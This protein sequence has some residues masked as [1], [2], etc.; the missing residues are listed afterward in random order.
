[1]KA[2]FLE[3]VLQQRL[4][5]RDDVLRT[6]QEK[7]PSAN[8]MGNLYMDLEGCPSFRALRLAQVAHHLDECV[9]RQLPWQ[10][11]REVCPQLSTVHVELALHSSTSFKV[12]LPSLFI[13]LVKVLPAVTGEKTSGQQ[14]QAHRYGQVSS[15]CK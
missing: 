3:K 2:L 8:Q 13:F 14:N 15:C 10:P 12:F 6:Q 7:G 9:L 11:H 5:P 4:K 1:M